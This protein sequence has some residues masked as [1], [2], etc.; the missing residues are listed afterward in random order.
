MG[1]S[2]MA[3]ATDTETLAVAGQHAPDATGKLRLSMTGSSD[4]GGND[5]AERLD[6]EVLRIVYQNSQWAVLAT[7]VALPIVTLLIWRQSA[8][9]MLWS[10]AGA[11]MLITV[12]RALYLRLSQAAGTDPSH[13]NRLRRTYLLW[14]FASG[15]A[16]GASALLLIPGALQNQVFLTF[17]LAGIAAVAV[18]IHAVMFHAVVLFIV[19]A[20]LPTAI[21]LYLEGTETHI[22]MSFASL[23]FIFILLAT[24]LRMQKTGLHAV[25]LSLVNEELAT[26]LERAKRATDDLNSVL[27]SEVS[28]RRMMEARMRMER[29]FVSAVLDTECGLVIVLDQDGRIVRFNRACETASG[30]L[31]H[32]VLGQSI[33]DALI[34]PD[35]AHYLRT[36]F[37]AVL[38]GRFPNECE[39]GWR[40]K[41]GGERRIRLSNTALIDKS[42]K[43]THIVATGI[44]VTDHYVAELELARSRED[45]R[46][47]VEGVS[48]YAIY[49]LDPEGRIN[50]W[51]TGAEQITGYQ[52]QDVIGTHYSRFYCVEDVQ[53]GRATIQLSIAASEGRHEYEGWNI[54][55]N[56][57]RFWAAVTVAPLHGTDHELRGFSVIT[58][59]LTQRK[60]TED[61][62]R[63]LLTITERLNATLDMDV[64]MEALVRQSLKLLNATGG[65][66]GLIRN[67]AF[68]C[69]L[70]RRDDEQRSALSVHRLDQGLPGQVYRTRSPYRSGDALQDPLA[71]RTFYRNQG[72]R[73]VICCPIL[74][75]SGDV[76]GFI[77]AHNKDDDTAFSDRDEERLVSVSQ[78]ASLAIQNALAFEQ[79]KRTRNLLA[80][81]SRLLELIAVGA[82]LRRI[83]LE[84]LR[85]IEA[86]VEGASAIFLSL[87]ADQ[88]SLAEY[89][90]TNSTSLP[91][92][93]EGIELPVDPDRLGRRL[94]RTEAAPIHDVSADAAWH[95]LLGGESFVAG[96]QCWLC[97][98]RTQ[99]SGLLGMLVIALNP[100]TGRQKEY[101]GLV[102]TSAHLAG[103][104][105]ER[106]RAEEQLHES[107]ERARA[108]S[109]HLQRVREEEK[110][111]LARELHDELGSTLLA[112]K[113]DA[114]WVN[115]HLPER[116][117]DIKEKTGAM[118][119][120]VDSAVSTTRRICSDLRPPM[121]DDLGLI[122]T[123]EWQIQEF[124]SRTGIA[125]Q[126]DMDGDSESLNSDQSIALF[127]VFQE[128]FTNVARHAQ[129]TRI[130]VK[131]RIAGDQAQMDIEDNG[132]GIDPACA[133]RPNAHG[134]QGMF[135]R[136]HSLRGSIELDSTPGAGTHL[137]VRVP[138]GDRTE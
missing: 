18:V 33:W 88:S 113:I 70:Y 77:E 65:C 66:S 22:A 29:D 20:L 42:G 136:I 54:R 91:P 48:S 62:I 85:G 76:I 28:E 84:L 126:V 135:E 133:R 13:I 9:E 45:F 38:S 69:R 14:S 125:C 128:A 131:M 86:Y 10:W 21:R 68:E 109:G 106:H 7:L 137:K 123:L 55:K 35:E 119:A 43:P 87:A 2:R 19:P 82:P 59:D 58:G 116:T 25:R 81:E 26:H 27:T 11:V 16:W 64:L 122:A 51:N 17:I 23:L 114:A 57:S 93:P 121:L 8:P 99:T 6:M 118:L 130:R 132:R 115:R 41:Q 124:E 30:Y 80:E 90:T 89:L 31:A 134:L 108:L 104:A 1:A 63:A 79:I 94:S 103:I 46:L 4:G 95:R 107:R 138:L 3:F 112:L 61:T 60:Q 92:L 110:A 24:A 71:D 129:A 101:L 15:A 49:M 56:G 50:S 37:D 120:L 98:V 100:D 117:D 83:I 105:L 102:E 32:E 96:R 34:L 74:D 5:L 97:L 73:A 111:R 52:A 53:H 44:D 36:K 39:I 127:R 40:R 67:G 78:S 75:Y 47:L 72:V 12:L